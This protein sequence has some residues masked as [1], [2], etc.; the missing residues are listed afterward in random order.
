MFSF[1]PP[2]I[3]ALLAL[4]FLVVI[5]GVL[6]T[7]TILLTPSSIHTINNDAD[8]NTIWRAD[9][10]I[11]IKEA[12]THKKCPIPLPREATQI[13]FVDFYQYGGF[14][15]CVRFEAQPSVCKAHAA[16]LIQEFNERKKEA[17]NSKAEPLPVQPGPLDKDVAA[18]M[19]HYVREQM[20]EQARAAWFVPESVVEGELWG[21]SG[22]HTPIIVID[23]IKGVFY[24]LH[25][26]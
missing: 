6:K 8:A 15:R 11:N 3:T 25:T 17:N 2:V 10:P 12:E 13:Q 14:M 22:S 18:S 19:G 7:I 24:Y 20:E 1:R 16:H 9:I 23:T 5:Y 4:G 21:R 26:D